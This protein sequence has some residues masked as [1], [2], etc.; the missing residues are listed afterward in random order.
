MGYVQRA[1]SLADRIEVELGI[2]PALE[3]GSKGAFEILVD[4]RPLYSKSE[5]RRIPSP[6]HVLDLLRAL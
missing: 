4:G 5:T 1:A 6:E 2:R 3:Q